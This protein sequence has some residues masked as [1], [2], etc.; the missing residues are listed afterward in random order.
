MARRMVARRRGSKKGGKGTMRPAKK[1]GP[2]KKRK[3]GK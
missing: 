3:G 1:P 2:A